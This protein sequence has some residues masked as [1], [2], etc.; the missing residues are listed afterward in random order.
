MTVFIPGMDAQVSSA[1]E[2]VRAVG[3][4]W[5][6]ARFECDMMGMPFI[7]IGILG[8]DQEK[9]KY[10]GTWVDSMRGTITLMEGTEAEDGTLTMRWE[11]VNPM[12]GENEPNWYDLKYS[13]REY[14]STFYSGEGTKGMEVK[15][16]RKNAGKGKAKAKGK[17]KKKE[18]AD[19]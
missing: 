8:Y 9:E 15:M 5:T 4:L 11:A 1:K 18:A 2:T 14:T 3:S 6:S 13:K 7:G 16:K 12:T 17:A 19:K 10:V